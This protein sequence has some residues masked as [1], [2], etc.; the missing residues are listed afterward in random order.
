MAGLDRSE[1][2]EG[3][4]MN[5]QRRPIYLDHHA[6][7]PVHPEV[8]QAMLPWFTERFGNPSSRGH[9]FGWD[10]R[11][12]VESAREALGSLLG[13]S[14][15]TREIVF[16]SGATEA[17]NLAIKGVARAM[18]ERYGRD[19]VVTQATEHRSVLQA[20]E[21]LRREGFRVTVVG[22]DQQGIVD[23]RHI[24]E[25]LDPDHTA[26]VTIMLVNNEVGAIQP[27]AEVVRI[28]HERGIPVHTDAVQGIGRVEPSSVRAL[29]VDL[30]SLSAHKFG[31]P[32]GCGAL[33]VRRNGP[34][35][36]QLVPEIEGGGHEHGLRS[37]TL[38][39]PGI[40]GLGAAARRLEREGA[41]ERERMRQLRDALAERILGSLPEVRLNGPPLHGPRHPGNLHLSFGYVDGAGLLLA[42]QPHIALSTGSACSTGRSAPSHVLRAMGVP[43]A[44][45]RA[46]F[47]FGIGPETSEEDVRLAA[48]RVVEAV[49]GLRAESPEWRMKQRGLD[50]ELL[51]W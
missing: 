50:P 45:T 20:C 41:A 51:D 47:R 32:K 23:P 33:Y 39:V 42:L 8:L 29:D 30:L 16:T 2:I 26:L 48:D 25:A 27:V 1:S 17:N 3:N 15:P 46:S 11:D 31:G 43:E 5:G 10:A 37:G 24:E 36:V 44:W 21:R 28:A 12:A 19:H 4:A 9:A 49:E 35:P 40:V 14:E 13:A 18:R 7:T 22:V 6:T 38:N 34:V